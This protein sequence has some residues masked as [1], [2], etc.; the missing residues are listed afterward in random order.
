[1]IG[2]VTGPKIFSLGSKTHKDFPN[3]IFSN[4]GGAQFSVTLH[5][6]AVNVL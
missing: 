5:D 4:G 1:M 3:G 6:F 2:L